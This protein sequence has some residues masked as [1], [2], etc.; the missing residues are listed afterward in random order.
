MCSHNSTTP[1]AGNQGRISKGAAIFLPG[2]SSYG[3]LWPVFSTPFIFILNRETGELLLHSDRVF[4]T[5]FPDGTCAPSQSTLPSVL[6]LTVLGTGW[7]GGRGL[8]TQPIGCLVLVSFL[9]IIHPA[10]WDKGFL[11]PP[12]LGII[13]YERKPLNDKPRP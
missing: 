7:Q 9:P 5:I 11:F 2:I 10:S 1:A 3:F 8:A 4:S 12:P 6:F 13:V